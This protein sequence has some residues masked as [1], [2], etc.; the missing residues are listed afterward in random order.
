MTE[1]M[2][3]TECTKQ[4]PGDYHCC[5]VCASQKDAR[6]NQLERDKSELI[7]QVMGLNRIVK[8]Q[9]KELSGLIQTE[10]PISEIKKG[11]E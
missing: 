2:P 5:I 9:L 6:I 3:C 10:L 7:D 1:P 8:R 11:I 4:R